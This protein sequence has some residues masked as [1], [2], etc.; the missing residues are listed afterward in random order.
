M[1]IVGIPP[2]AVVYLAGLATALHVGKLPPALPALRESLGITLVQAGWLVSAFQLAGMCL[3]LF[4]GLVADRFG[5]RRTMACGLALMALAGAAGALAADFRL[6]LASRALE[7]AAFILSVLPGPAL[8]RRVT[9]PGR[10]NL[11]LGVWGSY[12]PAGMAIALVA[13]PWLLAG[14]GWRVAWWCAA[15]ASVLVWALVLLRLPADPPQAAAPVRIAALARDTLAC[16]GPWLLALCFGLYAGQWMVV[17]SFLPTV[18]EVAGMAPAA[19]GAAT[20]LGVAVNLVGNIAAGPLLQ[21]GVPRRALLLL[22]S[23]TMIAGGWAAFD[24]ELAFAWR[25]AG[26]LAF[27]AV[28]GLIPGSLFAAAPRFAPH[29]GA[30]STTTGLMQQGSSLGQFLTP[31]LVAAVV[32]ASGGWQNTWLVTGALATANLLVAL[33]IGR[34]G[35]VTERPAVPAARGR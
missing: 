8:L 30:V 1:S 2:A 11:A 19:A 16:P 14:G 13:V 31:P 27:S 33:L 4:G 3:G 15:L 29:A 7:S 17:F 34:V 9:P 32:G 24:A 25:Y 20:A 6:L 21:R 22:G 18:Y 23:L 26:V 35:Q 12:M 5:L 28:G 10:M